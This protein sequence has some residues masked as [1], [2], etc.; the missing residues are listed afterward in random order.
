MVEL[1]VKVEVPSIT[2]TRFRSVLSPQRFEAFEQ[3]EA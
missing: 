1:E 2:C 3:N